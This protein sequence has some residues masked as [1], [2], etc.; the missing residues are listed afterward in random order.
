MARTRKKIVLYAMIGSMCGQ[1]SKLEV[2]GV[3]A[4]PC[5][6]CLYGG[7]NGG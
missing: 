2:E 3:D 7:G 1:R 5:L 6:A 4:E